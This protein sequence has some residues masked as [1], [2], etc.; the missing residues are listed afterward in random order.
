MGAAILAS[1]PAEVHGLVEPYIPTI[2]DA[3]HQAFSIATASTFAIGIVSSLAAAG[4][5]LLFREAPATAAQGWDGAQG[6]AEVDEAA[7]A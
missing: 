6:D 5:V 2:V 7:A 4:L 3:I 1:V